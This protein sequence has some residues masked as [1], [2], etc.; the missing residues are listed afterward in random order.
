[1]AVA[2]GKGRGGRIT[3]KKFI[4]EVEGIGASWKLGI[5]AT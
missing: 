5:N 1:M 3:S 4:Q 2:Q